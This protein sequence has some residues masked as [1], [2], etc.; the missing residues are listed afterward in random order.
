MPK[1]EYGGRM[2]QTQ[3]L[4]AVVG[5]TASGK[6]ALAARLA[7]LI[8]ADGFFGGAQIISGDAFAVYRGFDIGTAKPTVAE[9]R[10]ATYRMIDIVD[11]AERFDVMAF[12]DEAQTIIA[13]LAEKN[14]MPILAGGTGLYIKALL[15]G[16]RFGAEGRD[17]EFRRIKT[18]EGEKFGRDFLLNELRAKDRNV[19]E[20]LQNADLRRIV[21][22]LERTYAT[23]SGVPAKA[24]S[25]YAVTGILQ[26]DAFVVGI[27][28]PREALYARIDE[29]VKKMLAAGLVEEVRRLLAQ[30]ISREQQAMKA[31]GYKECAAFLAG[32]L[33]EAELADEIAK[34]TR[35][36]AKRQ[37]TWFRKMPYIKWFSA[38]G[39][40]DAQLAAQVYEAAAGF[41]AKAPNRPNV[42][43]A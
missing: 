42:G 17:D 29:R 11:P 24:T 34:A 37:L 26:Y 7:K 20:R 19:A 22:A 10:E 30:G 23:K 28:W 2:G 33:T 5:A 12:K 21:R 27:D 16:Y 9:Q 39:K 36:F 6:S 38:A 3:K 15:E 35:H 4:I 1:R 13:D 41:W 32:E 40:T 31:I 25:E 18:A 43:C 8:A 14:V